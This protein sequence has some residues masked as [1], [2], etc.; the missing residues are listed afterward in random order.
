MA[1]LLDQF[2]NKSA[3]DAETS[4][5]MQGRLYLSKSGWL[6]M[7]VP[8]SLIRGVFDTLHEPGLELPLKDGRLNAHVSVM[9]EDE[10]RKIGE[11]NI[12]E[13]GHS[14]PFN[15]GPLKTV[16][17]SN[18]GG[19]S[20]VWYVTVVSPELKKLRA[21]YGLS[22]LPNGDWDFHCTVAIRKVGVIHD[23]D[24]SKAAGVSR[25]LREP[26]PAIPKL[27][28]AY[29]ANQIND[30]AT[31]QRILGEL[32]NQAPEEWQVDD[33]TGR[34]W[35]V[36][37]N[38]GFRFHL[39]PSAIPDTVLARVK[40]AEDVLLLKEAEEI[41]GI[42]N[43]GN[44][45]DLNNLEVGKMLTLLVQEH[46]ARRA[47]HHYDVRLGGPD[48]GLFS[49]ATRKGLP[50][51]G[52]KNL[53]VQQP[54]HSWGYKD[55]EGEIPSGYGAGTVK[56]QQE[57]KILLT[58]VE[59]GKISFSTS[60]KKHPERFNL[61]KTQQ[62]WLA[63]NVTP[64]GP[65]GYQKL[66]YKMVPS[67]QMES[68]L[69]NFQPGT[70][71][72]AKID[73]ASSLVRLANHSAD[74]LSYRT[75]RQTGNPIVHTERVFGGR[76]SLEIPKPYQDSVLKGEMYGVDREGKVIHP[77][78]LGAILNSGLENSL[79]MQKERGIKLRNAL[80]D[81]QQMGGRPVDFNTV[82]YAERRRMLGE[83]LPHLPQDVF[84]LSP[85]ATNPND[86]RKMWQQIQSGSHPLTSEGVVIHQPH[87]APIKSKIRQDS[88]VWIRNVFP[89]EGKYQGTGAGG[90]EYSLD[91]QGQVLGRVGTGLS[92][93]VRRNMWQDPGAYVGRV[94]KIR[95]QEQLPSGA[96]RAPAFLSLHEDIT[97]EP[98]EKVAYVPMEELCP[99][100]GARLERNEEGF[101]N[102]CGEPWPVKSASEPIY[103]RAFNAQLA[104]PS[105]SPDHDLVAN[106]A[107]NIGQWHQR[108]QHMLNNQ[109]AADGFH[110]SLDPQFGWDHL[111]GM[112]SGQV[113]AGPENPIDQT[114]FL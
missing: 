34:N 53:F 29:S 93:E 99:N 51:P 16:V 100:C 38:S 89:G 27:Q 43:R 85:E 60:D 23:N 8:N 107:N 64:T 28:E 73:G 20:R 97:G 88:D 69:A 14:I 44:Y 104:H 13:R 112:L 3:G 59:P 58:K 96:F 67:D 91:P 56:K 40:V 10:V 87:G 9:D 5:A 109:Y 98:A 57:R 37:H 78:Q 21:S 82:P 79:K 102:S 113:A 39:P 95:S 1:G 54:I 2:L 94:A 71:V 48:Q 12:T 49:W 7:S 66:H 52:D 80:F 65:T 55:F 46:Q 76:P 86:A 32:M 62:G 22:P 33:P 30:Y 83:I 106:L 75:S 81:I 77:S 70:S 31:K 84:H 74:L 63:M 114:L 68:I 108:G 24:K 103:E 110:Q 42:S 101:C 111:R 19:W 15:L 6:L 105:W 11:D 4:Y 47:G 25:V 26:S 45:G 72:Q 41:P 90:F 36:T 92:D 17:P 50:Q 35:G 61:I 18:G